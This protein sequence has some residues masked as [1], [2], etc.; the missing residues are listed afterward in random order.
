MGPDKSNASQYNNRMVTPPLTHH[1]YTS[2]ESS[3]CWSRFSKNFKNSG[4]GQKLHYLDAMVTPPPAHQR[5]P[6]IRKKKV[7]AQGG[8]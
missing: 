7:G 3:G 8:A 4:G 1:K 6:N 2:I 5:H